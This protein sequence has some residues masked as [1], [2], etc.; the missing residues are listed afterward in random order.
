MCIDKFVE[1]FLFELFSDNFLDIV[2]NLCLRN[3]KVFEK[4]MK[5]LEENLK[6]L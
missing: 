5:K 1:R 2:L 4:I 6:S 3:W